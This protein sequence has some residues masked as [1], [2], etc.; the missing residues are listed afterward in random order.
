MSW[1]LE[2]AQLDTELTKFS[3][4]TTSATQESVFNLPIQVIRILTF[5]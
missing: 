2:P 3:P 5:G 1:G 4:L